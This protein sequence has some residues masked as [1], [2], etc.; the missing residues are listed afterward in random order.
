MCYNMNA[1][2]YVIIVYICVLYVKPT[3]SFT[4]AYVGMQS[5]EYDIDCLLNL[6]CR[7][8]N[9]KETVVRPTVIVAPVVVVPFPVIPL[10]DSSA[11]RGMQHNDQKE[12]QQ[13][14]CPSSSTPAA[15]MQNK[16]AT[17]SATSTSP[18]L[19]SC[20]ADRLLL[21]AN[22]PS[23]S[24]DLGIQTDDVHAYTL[25]GE[26]GQH[27]DLS[28]P[29]SQGVQTKSIAFSELGTQ[30]IDAFDYNYLTSSVICNDQSLADDHLHL[31]DA[32]SGIK[33]SLLPPECNEL[34]T[35]TM[36]SAFDDISC[37]DFGVQTLL[38]TETRD[39]GSQTLSNLRARIL[40]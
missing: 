16:E 6:T 27:T 11:S 33:L 28:I 1:I 25:E 40:Q 34:G 19:L 15:N 5:K 9:P 4:V 10:A 7:Q 31:T 17:I 20:S 32:D 3:S 22:C 29:I 36:E 30:T 8:T 37:L 23:T 35:Q 2:F 21:N 26:N 24:F 12:Q 39:Q 18:D 14:Q 13:I 38:P